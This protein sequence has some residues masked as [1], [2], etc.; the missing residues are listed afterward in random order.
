MSNDSKKIL[1]LSIHWD[2]L[3]ERTVA[4]CLGGL[5]AGGV[6]LIVTRVF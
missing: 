3:L 6:L 4:S 2:T 1:T 5:I